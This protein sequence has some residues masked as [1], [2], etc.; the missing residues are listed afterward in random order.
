MTSSNET[1]KKVLRI[2]TV[3]LV[4]I[5]LIVPWIMGDTMYFPFIAGKGLFI[6]AMVQITLGL[7][8][9]LAAIDPSSR[10]RKSPLLYALIA[11]LIIAGISV[12]TS[13]NPIRSFFSNYER[14]EGYILVLHL[15]ALFVIASSVIRKKEWAWIAGFSLLVSLIVGANALGDVGKATAAAAARGVT[16][17][18]LETVK[19]GVRISG[20]LGNSS[21][22]GVYALIHIFLAALGTLMV[23]RGNREADVLTAQVQQKETPKKQSLTGVS[24]FMIIV[25]V[26]LAVFNLYILFKTG[27][28]GSFLGLVIGFLVLTGYLT[29]KE[30]HK[31][32]KYCSMGI[33]TAIIACVL[34]LGIFKNSTF[35]QSSPQLSR[36][37]ALISLDVKNVVKKLGE[38][39]TMI[40]GMSLEGVKERPFFGWG[41]DNYGYVFAKYYDPGM[42]AREHWFDRSHNVFIDWMIAAGVLGFLGYLSFFVIAAWLLF[43]KRTRLTVIERAS[44]LGLLAAY[45]IHNLFVFD[46]LTSYVLFFLLLSYI[47]DRYTHDRVP[48]PLIK[49]K[50]YGTIILGTSFAVILVLAYTLYTTVYIPYNQNVNLVTA[51][52][53]ASQQTQVT[54][55]MLS[56]VKKV[57]MDYAYDYFKKIY[58]AGTPT[59]EAFEQLSGIAA[60]A[61][62]SPTVPNASK[63]AFYKLYNDQI[64]YVE[65]EAKGDPR[66]PFFIANFFKQ[67]GDKEQELVYT[68]KAYDLSPN[69]QS[70]G[71]ALALAQLQNG[72]IAESVKITKHEYEVNQNNAEALRYYTYMAL[73][74]AHAKPA[75]TLD[76]L[77]LGALAQVL[78]DGY[79]KHGHTLA[80]DPQI[81][82][83]FVEV[84][85]GVVAKKAFAKRLGELVP[86]KKAVFV[87]LAK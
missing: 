63:L 11:F 69:K 67:I 5:I 40:W 27:T 19:A 71:Y 84:K 41:Q 87:N 21:Y 60:T 38:D 13:V 26:L 4:G 23:F 15:G 83:V 55:E 72:N 70:F 78:A 1:T 7:Y 64:A 46:N 24:W 39:R 10:P 77:K 85:N 6:R 12:L 45:F 57:P 79:I 47:H 80:F 34:L 51:M 2:I 62:T 81:W 25:G 3:V 59:S 29:F 50:D 28:R 36:Y 86:E 52:G 33:F 43:S 76:L 58:D 42:Y 20:K 44:L 30:K 53:A 49:G 82:T 31:V 37:S 14:M 32:L 35:V 68:Q 54:P 56:R 65:A 61:I 22:L 16:G 75:N 48:A 66:Y 9:V 8:I 73:E 17:A 18:E 74:E